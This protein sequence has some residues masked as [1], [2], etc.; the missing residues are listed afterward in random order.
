MKSYLGP[1]LRPS[2]GMKKLDYILAVVH[3]RV[4][5]LGFLSLAN[6]HAPPNLGLFDQQMALRFLDSISETLRTT[7]GNSLMR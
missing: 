1:Y 6:E 5:V 7:Q 3:Y 4:G 2:H